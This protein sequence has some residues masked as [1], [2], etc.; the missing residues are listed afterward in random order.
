MTNP[1][2]NVGPAS[3]TWAW[4]IQREIDTLQKTM[5]TR[6]AELSVRIDRV[7]SSTEYNAD[8]RATEQQHSVLVERV[9][10]VDKEV[11][12]FK[13]DFNERIEQLRKEHDA[14]IDKVGLLLDTEKKTR[15]SDRKEDHKSMEEAANAQVEKKRWLIAA[16]MVP[17]AIALFPLLQLLLK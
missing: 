9:S 3:G 13:R 17:T 11:E 15:E 5:E 2:E 6:Y 7:V 10:N 8:K 14:D 1:L 4:A 12:L 16:I